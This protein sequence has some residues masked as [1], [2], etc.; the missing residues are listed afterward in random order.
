MVMAMEQLLI[1]K[2]LP[3]QWLLFMKLPGR[4]S[5]FDFL[6]FFVA[7]FAHALLGGVHKWRYL[8]SWMVYNGKSQSKMDDEMG[9]LYF[10]NPPSLRAGNFYI[11]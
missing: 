6:G 3:F 2:D 10:K 8:N 7:T 5:S 9:Y 1:E 4:K 11:Q